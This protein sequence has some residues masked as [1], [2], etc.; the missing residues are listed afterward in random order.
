MAP[1]ILLIEDE[2]QHIL[3][4]KIRLEIRGY[5][6][7][8]AQTGTAGLDAAA[9]LKPDLVLLDLVLPDMDPGDLIRNLR[10]M[11]ASRRTPIIAFTGLD[12]FELHRGRLGAEIAEF[13]PKPYETS[14]LLA[15]I[16]A[17]IGEPARG[18]GRGAAGG[19]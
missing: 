9:R 18:E 17:L 4:V 8:A 10:A 1:R 3:L 14:E 19:L 6:V 5:E 12:A 15:K 7:E 13:V 2:P 16:A 11:P